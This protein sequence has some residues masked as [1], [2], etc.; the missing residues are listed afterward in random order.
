MQRCSYLKHESYPLINESSI[1][2]GRDTLPHDYLRIV[3]N[4]RCT[5]WDRRLSIPIA[6]RTDNNGLH[7]GDY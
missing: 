4:T 7:L 5:T 3:F 2:V 1:P 6:W